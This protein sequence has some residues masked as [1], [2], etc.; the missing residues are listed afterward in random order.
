MSSTRRDFL[1]ASALTAAGSMLMPSFTLS[2]TP[3]DFL[4]AAHADE[5]LPIDTSS[6]VGR[7][8]AVVDYLTDTAQGVDRRLAFNRDPE[9]VRQV[10]PPAD[11]AK[12]LTF[13]RGQVS[14]RVLERVSEAGFTPGDVDAYAEWLQRMARWTFTADEEERHRIGLEPTGGSVQYTWPKCQ[15]YRVDVETASGNQS[16][17]VY[18]QGVLR[19]ATLRIV[20]DDTDDVV[21]EWRDVAPDEG[22]TFRYGR[23]TRVTQL[24]AG[25]YRAVVINELGDATQFVIDTPGGEFEI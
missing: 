6:P 2:G 9:P 18:A 23:V 24:P 15:V 13:E 19:G 16:L 25:R 20:N 11:M 21:T 3:F 1:K 8:G 14:L 22:S 12:L 10:L 7:L 4:A 17:R 5:V